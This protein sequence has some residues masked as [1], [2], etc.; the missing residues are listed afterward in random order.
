MKRMKTHK[1]LAQIIS[2]TMFLCCLPANANQLNFLV[3][4][5]AIHFN[6]NTGDK[7]NESNWGAG[8]QYDIDSRYSNW[9]RFVTVSGFVDSYSNPSYYAGGGYQKKYNLSHLYPKLHVKAGV[10]GF[11]MWR[12]DFKN[13]NQP[14][15]GLL[16]AFTIGTNK[17][18]LNITYVPKLREDIVPSLFL[19]LKISMN[20]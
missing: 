20:N 18:A 9:T 5:K 1:L 10:V 2:I 17:A 14:F 13:G 3:N 16:P 6:N 7:L 15:P 19:Q 8:F 4:G 11:V 12:D